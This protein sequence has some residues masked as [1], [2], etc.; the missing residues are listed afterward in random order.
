MVILLVTEKMP[1]DVWCGYR[2]GEREK[3]GERE[4]YSW[5]GDKGGERVKY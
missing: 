4:G 2:H 5:N 1:T 3:L